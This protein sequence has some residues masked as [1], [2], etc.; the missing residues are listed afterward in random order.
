MARLNNKS[1]AILKEI[2][3]NARRD[4]EDMLFMWA[5]NSELGDYC[6]FYKEGN[7]DG[8]DCYEF[9]SEIEI[10]YDLVEKA[11]E[12]MDMNCKW[13]YVARDDYDIIKFDVDLVETEII[14]REHEIKF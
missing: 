8:F 10:R 12:F 7:E 5:Y 3:T 11:T 14:V 13:L 6:L 4:Y 2:I 9:E 1:L